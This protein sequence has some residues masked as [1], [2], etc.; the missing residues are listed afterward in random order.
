MIAM[1]RG[2]AVATGDQWAV[3][4]VNGV[5]YHVTI[6]TPPTDG[7]E[8]VVHTHM[9]VR[10]DSMTLY[11]FESTGDRDLFVVLIGLQGIGPKTALQ[12]LGT[13]GA[14]GLAGAVAAQDAKALTAVPGVGPKSAQRM[15]LEI[16]AKLDQ[17]PVATGGGPV[18]TGNPEREAEQALVSLGFTQA[19]AARAV[20]SAS[21]TTA[22]ELIKRALAGASH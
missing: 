5:G 14:E 8:V 4:D 7:E 13:L 9:V 19:E 21:G 16:A 2:T 11:A 22:E 6:P 1:L 20:S 10:E 17:F 3:I 18:R 12:T 15:L